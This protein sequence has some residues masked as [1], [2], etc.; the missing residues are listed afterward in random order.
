MQKL[1]LANITKWDY[2]GIF[3]LF[4]FYLRGTDA[5]MFLLYIFAIINLLRKMPIFA[6]EWRETRKSCFCSNICRRVVFLWSYSTKS[7]NNASKLSLPIYFLTQNKQK[8]FPHVWKLC[9]GFLVLDFDIQV[10]NVFQF[11]F[12]LNSLKS[13]MTW[14][15]LG[16]PDCSIL[17]SW[18]SI[19]SWILL[20]TS[21][22]WFLFHSLISLTISMC[23]L[24]SAI[25]WPSFP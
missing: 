21:F 13:L 3:K 5:I 18:K 23:P 14:L 7:W 6:R 16:S 8:K 24:P 25:A 2:F 4:T 1:T 20:I 17:W 9:S 19:S 12:S 22:Y 10:F 11:L 15:A